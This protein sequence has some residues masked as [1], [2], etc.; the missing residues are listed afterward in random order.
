MARPRAINMSV[1]LPGD[2]GFPFGDV[3]APMVAA[4]LNAFLFLEA[5]LVSIERSM[6][7]RDASDQK[8]EMAHIRV[9]R[10]YASAFAVSLGEAATSRAAAAATLNEEL[11]RVFDPDRGDRVAVSLRQLGPADASIMIQPA[12][13]ARQSIVLTLDDA[14][15]LL[16][17]WN[18]GAL[19]ETVS[20][21]IDTLASERVRR[22]EYL[23]MIAEFVPSAEF[24]DRS[25]SAVLAHAK[26]QAI[27]STLAE[28]FAQF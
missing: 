21:T 8:K 16:A 5:F 9:A 28:A 3:F 22:S 19:D 25:P 18:A 10:E 12:A 20:Q 24:F 15:A 14:D 6:G 1:L 2:H 27:E 4:Y 11:S 7:A 23:A 17:K 26:I 13:R